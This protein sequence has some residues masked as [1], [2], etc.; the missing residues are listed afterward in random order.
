MSKYIIPVDIY[1]NELQLIHNNNV[2]NFVESFL[3]NEV[4]H[5][6]FTRAASSTGKYH[7][8]F[9][10]G[11]QGLVNHT[12]ALIK[13]LTVLNVSRP[14]LDWDCIYA[15]A[16]LHDTFKYTGGAYTNKDHAELVYVRI[17]E[18]MKKSKWSNI[19][20]E[21]GKIAYICQLHMGRFEE[22]DESKYTDECWMLHYADM[23]VSRTWYATKNKYVDSA[24]IEM[25]NNL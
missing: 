15:A 18:L 13:I 4:H 17:H 3:M 12:K 8:K 25:I 23:I 6:N 2:R 9:S 10:N 16:I 20:T 5:D 14:N 19:L 7:P 11:Y 24:D 1:A 21:L 22:P